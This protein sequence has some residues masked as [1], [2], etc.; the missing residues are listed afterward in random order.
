MSNEASYLFSGY[1]KYGREVLSRLHKTDKYE[2]AEFAT[3]ASIDDRRGL[4]IPWLFYP[5]VPAQKDEAERKIYNSNGLNQFGKWRFDRV[6]LDFKPDVVWDIRDFWMMGYEYN[7]PLRDYYNW[8]IMPTVD[9]APQ[10]PEW[11][12]VYSTADDVF[13]YSDWAI[14]VLDKQGSG[15]VNVHGSAPPGVDHN[16]FTPPANK[17]KHK[18][19]FGLFGTA[20]II[21]TVMR[22]QKRKLFP[23]LFIGFRKYLDKCKELGKNELAKNTFFYMHLFSL[24]LYSK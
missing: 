12:H 22:N 3:Y 5:N 24:H 13:T 23:D 14:D 2:I 21:G 1:S 15:M 10:Q 9:S 19:Q 20:K 17:A 16:V 4:S 8:T 18:E 7:S 11:V 6:L